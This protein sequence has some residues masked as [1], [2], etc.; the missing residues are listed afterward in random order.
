M[1]CDCGLPSLPTN[2][3]DHNS[4][5]LPRGSQ[6]FLVE[7]RRFM[8]PK[9][10]V[11]QNGDIILE[12]GAAGGPEEAITLDDHSGAFEDFVD[13]L[14]NPLRSCLLQ[15][16]P[17]LGKILNVLQIS[18]KYG[19]E[20]VEDTARSLAV[21]MT[22]KEEIKSHIGP[23]LPAVNVYRIGVKVFEPSIYRNA[24]ELILESFREHR[25]TARDLI[26]EGRHSGLDE[27]LASA[28]YE[29]MILGRER[30]DREG[31]SSKARQA[32]TRAMLSC[33][34]D[35]DAF[36]LRLASGNLED[37]RQQLRWRDRT[38]A[39]FIHPTP[40]N[41]PIT[42]TSSRCSSH[43]RRPYRTD[44]ARISQIHAFYKVPTYDIIGRLS[45]I[46]DE[47]SNVPFARCSEHCSS[48]NCQSR[49]CSDC[50]KTVV[51]HAYETKAFIESHL[52]FCFFEEQHQ[53]PGLEMDG[54]DTMDD[55]DL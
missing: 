20:V 9:A 50:W 32:L 49:H 36:V 42:Q 27:L 51:F 8:I 11:A 7:G 34:E 24:W 52:P 53:R 1:S 48:H 18:H 28:L 12:I 38:S 5:S 6:T 26:N 45:R 16:S 4:T 13:V 17:P 35:W 3:L 47:D 22:T 29:V 25:M 41:E 37:P 14:M 30:W 43:N 23:F 31:L 39:S 21:R 55:P 44:L 54:P 15:P 33:T 46:T 10:L 40:G 2:R 19:C